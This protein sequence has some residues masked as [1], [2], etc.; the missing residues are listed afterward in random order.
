VASDETRAEPSRHDSHNQVTK[1]KNRMQRARVALQTARHHRAA[2]RTPRDRPRAPEHRFRFPQPKRTI[3][4]C[5]C[6]GYTVSQRAAAIRGRIAATVRRAPQVMV[7]VTG[8]GRGMVAIAAH[9]RYISKNGRLPIEDDRGVVERGKEAL[10]AIERQWRVGGSRIDNHGSRREAYNIMLSMPRGTDPLIVYRAARE[11][12]RIE[13]ADHRYVM[14]LHDHQAHP[15]VHISMRAESKHGQR[16]NQRKADLQ[17]WRETLA[18]RLRGLGI[19]AEA[20]RQAVHGSRHRNERV[21]E[22]KTAKLRE[23]RPAKA[24]G[25]PTG[26]R[27]E[28]VRAWAEI[29]R[30]LAQSPETS[31][32]ELA[33]SIN[34]YLLRMPAVQAIPPRPVKSNGLAAMSC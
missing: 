23:L 20:S 32:R 13:L 4:A 21:W 28:A 22:R 16:L 7:K 3:A 24:E 26:T 19:E 10:P 1:M 29:M 34:R 11:F 27:K 31:D 2:H 30:A 15:H 6:R 17:R 8:G 18:E 33:Q 9:L 12:A 14:V 5:A 25:L